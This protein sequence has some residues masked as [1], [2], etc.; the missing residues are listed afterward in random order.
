MAF[1]AQ[2]LQF[3]E[4]SRTESCLLSGCMMQRTA[5]LSGEILLHQIT[6]CQLRIESALCTKVVKPARSDSDVTNFIAP[7]DFQYRRSLVI[8]GLP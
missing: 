3:F 7:Y 2:S 4:F 1:W 5:D 8:T 6:K